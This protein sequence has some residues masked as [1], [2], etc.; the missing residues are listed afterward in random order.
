M[1]L[2]VRIPK[3]EPGVYQMPNECP[4]EGCHGRAFKQHQEGCPKELRD[5]QHEQVE[6]KR[7][8]CL[9]CGRTFRVYPKGVSRAQQS[10][11]LKA[12]SVL[13][14]LLGLSY[15]AVSD[16]LEA[17]GML[18]S[19]PLYL[20]KTTVYRNVQAAGQKV[21]RL[22][23]AWLSRGQRVRVI[24]A[25][26]TKVKCK[27]ESIP[28]GVVVDDLTGI[29]L[30][31][32]ILENETAETQL[33]WIRE[34]AEVVGAEVLVSDDADALKTVADE[35]GLSHQVCRAHVTKNVL[36]L[37]GELCTQALEAPDPV[38]QGVK[39][40][41]HRP[42]LHKE[43]AILGAAAPKPPLAIPLR[44]QAGASWLFPVNKS[45]EQFLTDLETAQW[46]VE[47]HPHDGE[48]Q[49]EALHLAYCQAPA[50]REGEKAT[51]WYRMRLLTLDLWE[52]WSLLTLYQRWK[53][54]QGERLDGTNNASERAIGWW[55]KERYR[56]MRGYKRPESVLNVSSLLGWLGGQ[57]AGYNLAE[58]VAA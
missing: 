26:T 45:M 47:T 31:I 41:G 54:P 21:R 24:G 33:A 12:F 7:Y 3:V 17:L 39:L 35:L 15:G 9:R 1:R 43:K 48:A 2:K 30:T 19:K 23:Q 49:L 25:D 58:L 11:A 32:D 4:Y 20:A 50:P 13:L 40:P 6:A 46:L 55:I 38:P 51:I 5:P 8:R 37:V 14:Y 27:G 28:V 57:H 42:G 10:D 44:P 34:L 16:A 22:R 52:D 29:E 53:G 18:L 36:R 56:S